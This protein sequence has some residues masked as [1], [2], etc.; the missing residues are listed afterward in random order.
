MQL[1]AHVEKEALFR[2]ADSSADWIKLIEIENDI[3]HAGGT[4]T[5]K[6][7]RWFIRT[8][9]IEGRDDLVQQ[10]KEQM[11]KMCKLSQII[12]LIPS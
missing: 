6:T 3:R 4:C 11:A 2:Y 9:R 10:W 1:V 7:E 5:Y 8:Y 12:E